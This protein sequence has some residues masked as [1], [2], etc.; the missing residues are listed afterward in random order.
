MRLVINFSHW[1]ETHAR[2][3]ELS[4]STMPRI[5]FAVPGKVNYITVMVEP[6]RIELIGV[7][8]SRITHP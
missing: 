1:S 7:P 5:K 2:A 8:T 4:V 6:H 3:T